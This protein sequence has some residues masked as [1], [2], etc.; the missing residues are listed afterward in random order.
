MVAHPSP[1]RAAKKQL[2]PRV[3]EPAPAPDT[4]KL[5]LEDFQEAAPARKPLAVVRRAP[6]P[7]RLAGSLVVPAILLAGSFELVYAGK[8]FPGVSADGV[9]LGGLS[10]DEAE[11]RIAARV[12]EFGEH[13]VTISNGDTNLRIPVASLNVTYDAGKAAALA[14]NFGREGGLGAQIH[15][16]ARALLGHLTPLA[17]YTYDDERLIPYIVDLDDDVTSPVENA[18]LSFNGDVAQVTPSQTGSRLDLGRLID[19][20]NDRLATTSA[21]TIAAPVYQIQP[22][23]TTAPLA[24]AVSQ[25]SDY[26]SGPITVSYNGTDRQIDQ[27]TIIS[28]IEVSAN[29]ARPFTES[30]KLEDLNPPPPRANLELSK[31]A[32]QEY[33]ADLA[34]G[35]DQTAQNAALSMQSGQLSVVQPSQDG[36]NVDQAAAVDGIMAALTKRGDQRRVDLK[37]QSTTAE[38]NEDNL[39]QLGIKELIAEGET[40]FP[41][42]TSNRLINIRQGAKQFNGVL[43]KPGEQFSFGKIL[44]DVGPETGYVP[45]LVILQNH[46]EKQYGGGLCQV[47]S[48]AYRAALLAGLPIN[49]RHNHSFAVSYYTAPYGV[50]GVDAT[51]YYPQ[52]DLKFTNDTGSYILIQTTMSGTDLKFDFYGTKTKVGVIRGPQFVTGTTD[53]KQASHTVFWRDVQ[54]LSGNVI[55]TDEINTYYKPS[56]DFPV[57][58]QFN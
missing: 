25:M 14:Y 35:I 37:L 4:E 31:V 23:L 33:V 24:A 55:K 42:S 5:E 21:D 29:P 1:R 28:W 15:A 51:I 11:S 53:T 47:A 39:Q 48:T 22:D 52:V 8:I 30:L 26:L 54:D 43:L 9:Y 3:P 17:V 7:L 20:I 46:E 49:E 18:T 13:V 40:T 45:E 57:T 58:K 2:P 32:V 56:T 36:V 34:R 50:P 44:G 16:Q 27:N 38:V 10:Q 12:K 6:L 41:G 19:L